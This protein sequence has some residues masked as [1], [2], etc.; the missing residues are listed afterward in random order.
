[1]IA[2]SLL[3]ICVI[4][5]LVRYFLH[6]RQMESYVKHLPYQRPMHP[7]FGNV[8]ALVGKSHKQIFNEIVDTVK[9]YGTPLKGYLGPF[10][11]ITIDKPEDCKTVLMSQHCLDK[12]YLYQFYPSRVGIFTI[13]GTY[14]WFTFLV[15][16]IHTSAS[17]NNEST[18][19][20]FAFS[21][22]D[23]RLF[24]WFRRVSLTKFFWQNQWNS[25]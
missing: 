19:L 17:L 6:M 3:A 11:M 1:M 9:T 22:F 10:L 20:I 18:I 16:I 12:P 8:L 13:T 25:I 24:L 4:A 7:F 14:F 21:P 15:S 5:V 23:F 2:T